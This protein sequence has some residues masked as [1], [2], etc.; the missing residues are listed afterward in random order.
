M[1]LCKH[2]IMELKSRGEQVFVGDLLFDSEEA[3][4]EKVTCD[5]CG[6]YDDLFECL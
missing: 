1:K 4:E 3:E 6:E 2:C 5:W